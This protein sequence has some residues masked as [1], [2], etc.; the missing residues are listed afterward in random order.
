MAEDTENNRAEIKA[1][2]DSLPESDKKRDAIKSFEYI[3]DLN[4]R[5]LSLNVRE[6][7]AIDL[8]WER[9]KDNQDLKDTFF[10]ELS[11]MVENGTV[12]CSTGRVTRILDTL[13]G[14]DD[15]P[16]KIIPEAVIK[17]DMLFKA[18]K[19]R[20]E[21]YSKYDKD[22]LDAGTHPNQ[23]MIDNELKDMIR[24]TLYKEYVEQNLMDLEKFNKELD[25]WIDSI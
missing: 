12:V 24:E 17:Q 16:V 2:L 15:T 20:D 4:T 7:E 21:V 13:N 11:S 9:I 8:V 3:Y 14:L 1:F 25:S 10:Y 22:Q 18:S 23:N 6:T 5:N 19:L